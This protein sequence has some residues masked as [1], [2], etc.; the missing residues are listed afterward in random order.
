[1]QGGRKP[2]SQIVFQF[3]LG[4]LRRY[5]YHYGKDSQTRFQFLLGRL[6]TCYAGRL[7]L[8]AIMFQFLLGRLETFPIS[9]A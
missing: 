4:R 9:A 7:D 2:L 3:L 1:M 5:T 8:I 6:E